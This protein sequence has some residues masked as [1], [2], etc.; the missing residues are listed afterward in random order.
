MTKDN[1]PSQRPPGDERPSLR[2]NWRAI[3]AGAAAVFLLLLLLL[4]GLQAG[5]PATTQATA[6]PTPVPT[7]TLTVITEAGVLRRIESMSTL[8]TTMFRVDTVV[9]AKERDKQVF[10]VFT[11]KGERL[12]LFVKGHVTAGV[13][14]KELTAEDITVDAA[15]RSVNIRIPAA[16]ILDAVL[17]D[18]TVET[19][20]GAVPEDV[21]REALQTGLERGREQIAATACE[22]GVL[23]QATKDARQA[24]GD[25]ITLL[26]LPN[27]NIEVVARPPGLCAIGVTLAVT[28]TPRP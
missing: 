23:D 7:P 11:Q 15:N 16:K 5:T 10:L 27:Y 22:S 25:L 21:S 13:D 20:E 6:V 26:N 3:I 14:L 2:P 17:D 4:P 9:R 8:Q 18:Y 12:L 19:Y 28:P 1:A 24:F